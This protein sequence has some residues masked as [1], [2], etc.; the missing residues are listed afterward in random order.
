M[1]HKL[2]LIV[3]DGWGLAPAGPGNAISQA[4]T[5]FFDK[6]WAE[7]ATAKLQASGQDVGLPD[8]QMG[9]SEVNHFTIGAGRRVPQDLVRVNEA[10]ADGSF[11]TNEAL[12]QA[13]N[14]AKE[15]NS[16]FHVWGLISDGGI[17]STTAHTVA[18]VKA[19]HQAGLDRIYVHAVTDGRDAA[20]EGG[21]QFIKDL[22]NELQRI[23]A[24]RV[25]DIVGRYYAMDRDH[26]YERT[27]LA[28]NL[29][30]K[31]EG[32]QFP[33]AASGIQ[34]S[35]DA[36]V[37]DE[38]I[39]PIVV[40]EAETVKANDALV[41]VNFRSDR[42]RQIMERWLEKGPENLFITTMTRYKPE[43]KV[44]V[45]FPPV[46]IETSLG[47][48]ISDAGLKQLRIT[49][50]EKFAHMTFFL[51][52]K[53]EEPYPGEERVMFDSYSDIA[54]HDER[55]QMR[56]PEITTKMVE[57]ISAEKF[58]VIFSNICN[59]DMVGHSG[60]IPATIK[61]CEAV[62]VALSQIVP[63]AQAH[64]YDV[65]ITADHGNAEQ[66]RGEH[67]EMITSHSTN[68]VPFILVSDRFKELNRQDGSIPDVAPTAL[69]LMELPVP[70]EMTG[71]SLV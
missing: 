3:L 24:G 39:K 35:Y 65:I 41:M 34:A 57:E 71:Q 26:N 28:F 9:T 50:T 11:F 58:D 64:G 25:V 38:F 32:A 37:T 54:T 55:P 70:E 13:I 1:S 2:V 30:T 22:E 46:Q 18:V 67:D 62:D 16:A 33:D 5:P 19:A 63:A 6:L 47:K 51:N 60:N 36:K 15:N 68:L 27:D 52:C 45:M 23:G 20:P 66:M 8:G 40:D 61:G 53:R 43:F 69:T 29:Y 59:A 10:I 42:P 49:E 48:V 4:E 21:V 44:A 31:G 7:S 56:A 12:Q 17:H 14:H